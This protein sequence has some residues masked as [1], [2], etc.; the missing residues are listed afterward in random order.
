MLG[1]RWHKVFEYAL[2]T[3]RRAEQVVGTLKRS[4]ARLNFEDKDERLEAE[5]KKFV[6]IN[7]DP[8]LMGFLHSNFSMA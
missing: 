8:L 2:M 5:L 7:R 1:Y 3:K 6:G 4:V